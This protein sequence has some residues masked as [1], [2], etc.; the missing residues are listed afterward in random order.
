MEIRIVVP[1]TTHAL[2]HPEDF[3]DIVGPDTRITT[4]SLSTGPASIESEFDE[5]FAVPETVTRI[6]EAEADGADAVVVDCAADPGVRPGRE[7]VRIPVVGA[8][9]S[10]VHVAAQLAHRFSIVT[11]L[12]A[13]VPAMESQARGYGARSGSRRCA[14]SR[15]RSSSSRMT[16]STS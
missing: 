4:T 7:A 9:Q 6:M 5:A 13:A 2:T 8:L 11:V 3:A 10:S 12:E 16:A 14:P 1:I 15:F